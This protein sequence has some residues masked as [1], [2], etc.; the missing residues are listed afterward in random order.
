MSHRQRLR[1]QTGNIYGKLNIEKPIM[2]QNYIRPDNTKISVEGWAV[3]GVIAKGQE[4]RAES[5]FTL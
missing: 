2:N 1:Y 5:S 4:L 3:S